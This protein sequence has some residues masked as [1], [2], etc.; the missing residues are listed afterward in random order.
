MVEAFGLIDDLSKPAPLAVIGTR[1]MLVS[2]GVMGGLSTGTMTRELVDGR[3]AIRMRGTVSLANNGGFLQ[4]ALDLG[5]HGEPVDASRWTGIQLDVLG[6]GQTYNLHLRTTDLS[7]PWQS[8]RQS[9][10]AASHWSRLHLPFAGFVAHR[11][12]Q[13]LRLSRLQRIGLVAIGRECDVD[14]AIADIRFY[15]ADAAG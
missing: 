15:T 13:P 1:W 11:T 2:D 4:I 9:F 3:M 14:L 10:A 6:N 7:R 12:D 8:Y 5:K